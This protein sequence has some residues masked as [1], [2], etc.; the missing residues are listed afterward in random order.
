MEEKVRKLQSTVESLKE[1]D[2]QI[3]SKTLRSRDLADQHAFEKAQSD[4]EIRRLKDELEHQHVRIRE[5]QH[6]MSK[7]LA[8]ERALAERRYNYQ[9]DQLGGDLS[10]QWETATR[11]QL[12]LER[13]KRVESDYRRDV[14]QKNSQIDDLRNELKQ[15]MAALLSDVAQVNVEKQTLEQEITSL[16]LQAE[17]VDRQAKVEASRLN[18]EITSLRQRLDRADADLLHSKRENLRL[19]DQVAALE[20]E[21]C[22]LSIVYAKICYKLN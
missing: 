8:E 3:Y 2:A 16:R 7:K 20:K 10:N 12:E 15:K 6:D 14:Q 13:Q 11:L 5:I 1:K 4:A 19:G 9:V 18:A 17:R 21:V 22:L